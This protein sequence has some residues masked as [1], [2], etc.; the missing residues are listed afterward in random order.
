MTIRPVADRDP[1]AGT[2]VAVYKNLHCG[3]WSIRAVDGPHKGNVVA[4]ADALA[5]RHASMHVN[6]RAQARVAAGAAR[7]VHAWIVGTLADIEIADPVR[8]TYRPHE[9]PAFFID[10]G[11]AVWHAPAVVF[12]D[13]AYISNPNPDTS[14]DGGPTAN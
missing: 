12:T 7:E 4:H 14:R 3:A 2:R 11:Q 5:L 9:R 10:T 1:H 13:A 8:L 6:A